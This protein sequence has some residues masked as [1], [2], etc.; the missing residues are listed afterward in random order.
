MEEALAQNLVRRQEELR[1]HL[2]QINDAF[3]GQEVEAKKEQLILAE[4]RANEAEVIK[5]GMPACLHTLQ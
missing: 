1:N 4:G 3:R 2:S 5:K